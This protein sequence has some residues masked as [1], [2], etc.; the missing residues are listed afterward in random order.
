MLYPPIQKSRF[1]RDELPKL[2]CIIR[3]GLKGKIEVEGKVFNQIMPPNEHLSVEQISEIISYMQ[4]VWRHPKVA[5]NTVN[6]LKSC[7]KTINSKQ[8]AH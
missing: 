1:L 2:P 5:I 4:D 8:E 7:G 3:N 6:S